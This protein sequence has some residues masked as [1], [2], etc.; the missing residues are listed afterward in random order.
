M[1]RAVG[2]GVAPRW[3]MGPERRLKAMGTRSAAHEGPPFV[4]TKFFVIFKKMVVTSNPLTIRHISSFLNLFDFFKQSSWLLVDTPS[5][6]V[7]F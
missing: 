2:G 3:Q 4:F 1:V 7:R 5:D 6:V